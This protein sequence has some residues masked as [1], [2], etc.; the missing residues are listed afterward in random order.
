[1][2]RSAVFIV[3]LSRASTKTVT[4][5]YA[6]A[7]GT[8]VAPGDFASESGTLTFLPGQ[9]TK[10]IMIP[11]RDPVTGTVDEQFTVL[12]SSPVNATLADGTGV[13][14]IPGVAGPTLPVATIND[15]TVL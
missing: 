15:V 7:P 6:T 3:T 10:Q 2:A 8:A 1:M 13:C 4:V 5:A 11:I 12:L 9:T 14:I